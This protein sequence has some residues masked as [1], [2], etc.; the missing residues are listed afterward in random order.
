MSGAEYVEQLDVLVET[1]RPLLFMP[2]AEMQRTNEEMQA[3]GPILEP[4]AFMRGGGVNLTEQ[5]KV[6]DA[7]RR[8]QE[9]LAGIVREWSPS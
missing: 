4:T 2:L 1:V 9:V 7:A 5:R 8:L 3:L 6:I